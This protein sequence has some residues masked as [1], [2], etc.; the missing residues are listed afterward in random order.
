MKDRLARLP[1]AVRRAVA[2]SHVT[3][4][5]QE[6]EAKIRE[7]AALLDKAQDAIMVRDMDDRILYWNR[8]AERLYGWSAAEVMGKKANEVFWAADSPQHDEARRRVV[9]QGEWM[10]EMRQL[11][12]EGKTVIVESRWTLVRDQHGAPKAKLIINTDMTER[13][14]LEAQLLRSQRMETIGAL[15]GGIAHDLNNVLAPILVGIQLLGQRLSTRKRRK[16]LE[17]MQA[18][19]TRGMEMVRQILEFARGVGGEPAVLEPLG[20]LEEAERL[21]R[22]TFPKTIQIEV[23]AAPQLHAVMGNAT[24]LHQVLLNLCV[25]ARDA[26]PNGGSL[27]LEADNVLLDKATTRWHAEPASGPYVMLS[28]SDTGHGIPRELLDQIFEPFFTT[29]EV[30]KGTGLGLSTVL[31]IVKSHAGFLDVES[32][33]GRGTT[34]KV[35]LPA[36]LAVQAKA[37]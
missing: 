3:E 37:A 7:Q 11:T 4:L 6:A 33:V 5:R 19:A 25:N 9:R 12:R 32:E 35:F 28:V 30:G 16:V 1:S 18:R 17:T 8:S 36:Y 23:K 10:G 22:Q 15:S 34:F 31:G 14:K 13:K 24:Q 26:M 27:R 20:F 21:I 2:E 29:K